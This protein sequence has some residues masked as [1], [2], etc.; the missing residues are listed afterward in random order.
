MDGLREV[1]F[2]KRGKIQ[3]RDLAQA[4]WRDRLYVG[5]L[6]S[7]ATPSSAGARKGRVSKDAHPSGT[8]LQPPASIGSEPF[9]IKLYASPTLSAQPLSLLC[10][11]S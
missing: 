10:P 1:T 6:F 9:G 5:K 2:A 3:S 4:R 7:K 11:R 8:Q